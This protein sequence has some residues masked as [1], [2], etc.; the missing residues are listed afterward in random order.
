MQ[1][2][3]KK[4]VLH[5]K[6]SKENGI[7]YRQNDCVHRKSKKSYRYILELTNEFSKITRYNFITEKII[8]VSQQNQIKYLIWKDLK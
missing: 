3:R 4:K 6:E 1:Q 2:E 5:W 7:T 8:S